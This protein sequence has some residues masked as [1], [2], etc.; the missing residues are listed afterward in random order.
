VTATLQLT[1]Q[2]VSLP[3]DT[4]TSTP[5]ASTTTLPEGTAG[6]GSTASCTDSAVLL[7]DV[8]VPDN[9]QMQRGEKFTKTWR[10]KNNGKCNWSG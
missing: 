4:P 8:T 2:A 1:K 5:E 7:E 6:T 10:F 3:T 9:A